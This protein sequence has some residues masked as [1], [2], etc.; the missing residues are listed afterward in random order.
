MLGRR[1][2]ILRQP[3]QVSAGSD[4]TVDMSWPP[5]VGLRTHPG[6]AITG[7]DADVLSCTIAPGYVWQKVGTGA[8][9]TRSADG[10]KFTGGCY[11]QMT[12]PMPVTIQALS[13]HG[14]V[15]FEG[16]S[17]GDPNYAFFNNATQSIF[18]AEAAGGETTLTA[19]RGSRQL[20]TDLGPSDFTVR[21]LNALNI[22]H[23]QR[24]Q[25]TAIVGV[26]ATTLPEYEEYGAGTNAIWANGS[27]KISA[28]EVNPI[29][30][31]TF[32]MGKDFRGTVHEGVVLTKTAESAAP[33]WGAGDNV[34]AIHK[35]LAGIWSPSAPVIP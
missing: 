10:F 6:S 21:D 1:H 11:F 20:G 17:T 2:S 15:T 27:I 29:V 14:A 18:G 28:V 30:T 3:V 19:R 8:P 24:F 34:Q 32:I 5:A 26:H 22:M 35:A 13:V 9:I 33:L 25:S 16:M 12:L 4:L 31:D 7:T 23:D